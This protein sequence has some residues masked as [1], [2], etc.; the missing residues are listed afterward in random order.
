MRLCLLPHRLSLTAP[1]PLPGMPAPT[2][3]GRK[4]C[5]ITC[6]TRLAQFLGD[7]RIRDKV[8]CGRSGAAGDSRCVQ[9]AG[10]NAGKLN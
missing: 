10:G 3:A 7:E 9:L 8:R 6:A 4:S 5:A 2:P 1:S